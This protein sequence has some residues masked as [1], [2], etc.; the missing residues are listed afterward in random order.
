MKKPI[1]F[2][3]LYCVPGM[4]WV[5]LEI[6]QPQV[7]TAKCSEPQAVDSDV[8]GE[9][10]GVAIPLSVRTDFTRRGLKNTKMEFLVVYLGYNLRKYHKYR[11]KKEKS[12]QSKGLLN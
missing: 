5:Q 2:G 10:S 8:M 11:L 1:Y 12:T 7:V 3:F 4:A 9:G 6:N